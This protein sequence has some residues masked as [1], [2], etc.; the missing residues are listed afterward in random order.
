MPSADWK[1][2][3][4]WRADGFE[5]VVNGGFDD[6]SWWN[7]VYG[8]IEIS[9]G[10]MNWNSVYQPAIA[11]G[12]QNSV[13]SP[14]RT[15]RLTYTVSN[16]VNA[17]IQPF[18]WITG[19]A[20]Q[21]L[22]QRSANG[23]YTEEF[24]ARPDAMSSL[25]FAGWGTSVSIDDVSLIEVI[26]DITPYVRSISW[27]CGRDRASS[28]TGQVVSLSFS[29]ELLN[30]DG[31]FNSFLTSGP[32][33]G[34][35]LPGRNVKC[36]AT[37]DGTTTTQFTGYISAIQPKPE[38]G[39]NHT[40][41]ITGIGPLGKIREQAVS[42]ALQ[43]NRDTG[44]IV[45]AILDAAGWPLAD[46]VID[47]GATVVP[48]YYAPEKQ[49][50]LALIRELEASEGGTVYETKDGKIGFE[51]R[52]RRKMPPYNTSQATLTDAAGGTLGYDE[53]SQA[54]PME[55]IFN[56][57]TATVRI[58]ELQASAVLWT[59]AESGERSQSIAP[60][61]SRTFWTS[62]G[63]GVVAVQSW[64]TP[65]ATT[66]FRA[67]ASS[68]GTGADLTGDIAV[69]VSKF[70]TAMKITL[71]N[72]GASTA[73]ITFLQARGAA[74][75]E[76]DSVSVRA[77][78]APSQAAYG[79]REFPV[80]APWLPSTLAAQGCVDD[81]IDHYKDPNPV[82]TLAYRAAR[83]ADQ[84][85]ESLARDFGDRVTVVGN[86]AARLGIS[87]DM[88]VEAIAQSVAANGTDH[89]TSCELSSA[90]VIDPAWILGTS[91]L[92][93]ETILADIW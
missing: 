25:L 17:A 81:V 21:Y 86:G 3:V 40:A 80:D 71:T 28:L 51:S 83:S 33:Y 44:T 4:D 34:L 92:G 90:G 69:S 7:M 49:N 6:G 88:Y 72:N 43:E 46:R 12:Y 13:V 20:W 73:Y 8:G 78:D 26:D 60:G 45:G 77:E 89:R 27:R 50:V 62:I 14:G 61:E 68:G 91:V 79:A 5:R 65:V 31:R 53:I 52:M 42:V 93:T 23:T 47:T 70:A 84:V 22:T 85:A 76:L 39:G 38:L 56:K 11:V 9:G 1:I 55:E 2:Y 16:C 32:L 58:H 63:S 24:T 82:I 57:A 66:D 48:Y 37:Y 19:Y 35:L 75:V 64:T 18:L 59:L 54:D 29:I 74:L 10:K 36:T 30:Q 87:G 41:S 15:Y 67:N